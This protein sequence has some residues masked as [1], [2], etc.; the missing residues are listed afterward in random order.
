MNERCSCICRLE[1]A[2]RLPPGGRVGGKKETAATSHPQAR[3]AKFG[4][5]PIYTAHPFW[6]LCANFF[7][8]NILIGRPSESRSRDTT[9]IGNGILCADAVIPAT[10]GLLVF[11]GATRKY[12][13]D[14]IDEYMCKMSCNASVRLVLLQLFNLCSLE[15]T[16]FAG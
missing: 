3:I 8:S 6:V 7:G 2:E 9:P 13:E 14:I 1:Y 4:R 10:A 12:C 15:D 5:R 16:V 11:R